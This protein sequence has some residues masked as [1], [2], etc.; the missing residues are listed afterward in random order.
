LG[1]GA[2]GTAGGGAARR[3]AAGAGADGVA[4]LGAAQRRGAGAAAAGVVRGLL[5][6]APALG[7]ADGRA[8]CDDAPVVEVR[9]LGE[10]G[11]AGMGTDRVEAAGAA[12]RAVPVAVVRAARVAGAG[13][14]ARAD[15]PAAGA[16]AVSASTWPRTA[17]GPSTAATSRVAGS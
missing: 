1:V 16:G 6:R 10:V 14:A 2:D 4:G 13:A 7:A 9:G 5:G 17:E 8:R 15:R 12:D 3:R 11:A